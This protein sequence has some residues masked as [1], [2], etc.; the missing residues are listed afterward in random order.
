[1]RGTGVDKVSQRQLV[2]VAK[3]L[4]GTRIENG[5]L[6]RIQTS[7]HMDRISDLVEVLLHVKS[8]ADAAPGLPG[9]T[10][11]GPPLLTVVLPESWP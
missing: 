1:M 11:P 9:M 7:E 2:N 8:T 10:P 6:I 3:P 4:E 5:A